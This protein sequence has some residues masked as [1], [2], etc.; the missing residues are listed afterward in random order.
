MTLKAKKDLFPHSGN[1]AILY[2]EPLTRKQALTLNITVFFSIVSFFDT[3][4]ATLKGGPGQ[5]PARG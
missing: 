5:Y 4:R 1:R 3:V 2:S